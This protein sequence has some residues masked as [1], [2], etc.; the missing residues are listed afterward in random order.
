MVKAVPWAVMLII[1]IIIIIIVKTAATIII[2]N[3][4]LI[5]V[6]VIVI[7]LLIL[8]GVKVAIMP[9]QHHYLALLSGKQPYQRAPPRLSTCATT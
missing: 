1:I 3:T 4:M 9:S 5:I 2:I 6:I 8:V 7:I